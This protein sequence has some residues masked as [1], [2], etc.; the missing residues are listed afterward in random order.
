MTTQLKYA[1]LSAKLKAI[2]DQ[3]HADLVEQAYKARAN[4]GIAA[5]EKHGA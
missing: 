5:E 4:A 1:E 3:K 2:E